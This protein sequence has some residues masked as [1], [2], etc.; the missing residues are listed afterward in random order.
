M[1]VTVLSLGG[2]LIVQKKINTSY[3]DKFVKLINRYVKKGQRFVIVTGGGKLARDWIKILDEHG[4]TEIDES[5]IGIEATQ[6]NAHLLAGLFGRKA[7]IPEKQKDVK[8]LI[9]KHSIVI[10]G[11][12]EPGMTSDGDAVQ[13]AE[14]I[15]CETFINLTNVDGLYTKDPKKYKTAKHIP[16]IKGKEFLKIAKKVGYKPGQHFVLDM[17]AAKII[18]KEKID[19]FIVNGK[20]LKNFENLLAGK[21]Y[22]GTKITS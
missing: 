5:R 11:G 12:F 20:D 14:L 15:K 3:L 4:A 2:S 6:M 7:A 10:A 22:K 16:E 9:K 18:L 8:K 1:K 21:K 13:I 19:T 17:E